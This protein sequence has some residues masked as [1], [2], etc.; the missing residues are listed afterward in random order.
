VVAGMMW[1]Q[2]WLKRPI[3]KTGAIDHKLN[4]MVA[5]ASMITIVGCN[6]VDMT[7][8]FVWHFDWGDRGLGTIS[9]AAAAECIHEP[10]SIEAAAM[11]QP[12]SRI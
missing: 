11:T 8:R 2:K 4:G 10:Y 7:I 12:S 5:G 9:M 6:E 3:S 1:R